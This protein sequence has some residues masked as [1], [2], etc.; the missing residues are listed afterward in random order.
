[1]TTA[2]K[3]VGTNKRDRT[4]IKVVRMPAHLRTSACRLRVSD[5]AFPVR[6]D[7]QAA[8]RG[9]QTSFAVARRQAH[10]CHRQ[11]VSASVSARCAFRLNAAVANTERR[12]CLSCAALI[13]H[14]W[15]QLHLS[16]A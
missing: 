14:A 2:A 5:D 9:S 8:P 11:R 13:A 7:T 10:P 4:P 1:M 15:R 3:E 12:Q 6:T 16:C